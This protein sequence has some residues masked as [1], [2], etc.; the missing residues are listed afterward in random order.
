MGHLF[1]IQEWSPNLAAHEV[2]FDKAP[3][4]VQIHGLPM[5]MITLRNAAKIAKVIGDLIEVE[6]PYIKN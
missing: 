3:F 6:N 5:D 2:M 4:W 1:N